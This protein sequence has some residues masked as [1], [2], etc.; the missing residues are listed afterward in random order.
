MGNESWRTVALADALTRPDLRAR[1]ARALDAGPLCDRCLGR[2]CAQVDT[3]MGNDQRG[4]AIR[5]TL[6]AAPPAGPC[7]IC[8]GLFD[9]IDTWVA[10]SLQA[11]EGLEFDTFLVTS[12]ENGAMAERERAIQELA[13]GD[14]AEPYRQ[15]FNRLVGTRLCDARRA[16]PDFTHPDVV[17]LADHAE[18]TVTLDVRPLFVSGRYRKL[19]R[20]LPQCRWAAWTSSVQAIIGDPVRDA[21]GGEDHSF[22][23]CGRE[24]A[25]V[26]CLGER[27]FVLEV[28]RPRRRRL[29][30]TA[31]A[32]AIARSGAV[33]V[34]GLG[35]C[36]AEEVARVKS[37]RPEKTY[38]ALV[39]L[40]EPVADLAP[41]GNLA[42]RIRQRTPARALRSRSDRVR[43]RRVRSVAWKS[44]DARTV[45]IEVRT[46]AG[47]YVKELVSGDDGRTSPSVAEVLGVGA[48][49][50]ELDV[51]AI[52]LDAA[53]ERTSTE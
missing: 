27:P 42:G 15:E 43:H 46:Q 50:A 12:H 49:C 32:R 16:Q 26:R 18:G 29:D 21:A 24:D 22:H 51:L 10:R 39:R 20:G 36:A 4:A 38:R 1:L 17:V 23:G 48:E 33:Q 31:L 40:A 34:V 8:G 35:R 7:G 13:G 14:L 30:W 52:H 11:L 47:L 2:L 53:P 19:V 25:D 5:R 41:L 9:K 44:V 3:G 37:L 6:Q 28:L 45:E